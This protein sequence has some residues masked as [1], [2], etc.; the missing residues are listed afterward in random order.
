M[1]FCRMLSI[2]I[3]TLFTFFSSKNSNNS[4]NTRETFVSYVLLFDY[5]YYIGIVLYKHLAVSNSQ[6]AVLQMRKMFQAYV[7]NNPMLWG[8]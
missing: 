3:F 5:A 4:T 2:I 7:T 8:F 6:H 1:T